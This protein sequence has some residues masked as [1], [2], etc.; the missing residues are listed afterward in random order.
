LDWLKKE[1]KRLIEESMKFT[2]SVKLADLEDTDD[3]MDTEETV[4]TRE[5]LDGKVTKDTDDTGS[6]FVNRGLDRSKE[7]ISGD[8]KTHGATADS[9]SRQKLKTRRNLADATD[10]KGMTIELF[11]GMGNLTNAVYLPFAKKCIMIE[12]DP[13][14]AD[15]LRKKFGEKAQ[16]Y[17]TDNI[18]FIKEH[19]KE[20]DPNDITLVDFD[21]FGSA[22]KTINMFFD[23]FKVTKKIGVAITDG[24]AGKLAYMRWKPEQMATDLIRLGYPVVE[25][26]GMALSVFVWHLLKRLMERIASQQNCDLTVVSQNH[27]RAMTVYTSYLLEP[28]DLLNQ[29]TSN[30]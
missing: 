12:K 30:S 3:T 6:N 15:F 7:A 8:Y 14:Y 22:A 23:N 25:R 29:T 2:D 26:K 27:N 18:T 1:T 10:K 17:N 13:K 21:A 28:K 5:I 4:K 11:A 19:L 16:I 20:L 24:I 9:L